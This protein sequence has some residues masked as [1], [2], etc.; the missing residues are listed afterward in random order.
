MNSVQKRMRA[1]RAL[2]EPSSMVQSDS[3]NHTQRMIDPVI[4]SILSRRMKQFR[5]LRNMSQEALADAVGRSV[6]TIS[7]LERGATLTRLETIIEIARALSVEPFELIRDDAKGLLVEELPDEL[8][9]VIHIT[10]EQ[11]SPVRQAVLEHARAAV[12]MAAKVG[13]RKGE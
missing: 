2:Y 4:S 6:D 8:R 7:N 13:V 1:D 10:R 11:P 5:R 3:L 9:E 12:G